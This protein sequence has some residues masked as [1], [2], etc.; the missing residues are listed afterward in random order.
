ML[1]KYLV[2]H[3]WRLVPKGND[4][5]L[6]SP[7]LITI[8][9]V[10]SKGFCAHAYMCSFDTYEFCDSSEID[11]NVIFFISSIA[12]VHDSPNCKLQRSLTKTAVYLIN[13]SFSFVLK[14][15]YV[16]VLIAK[17]ILERLAPI[18]SHSHICESFWKQFSFVCVLNNFKYSS[19][20]FKHT[21]IIS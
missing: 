4:M 11:I 18:K 3:S 14:M 16:I 13:T 17:G 20:K 19:S 8:D 5:I 7:L 6:Y 21:N 9:W 12:E 15:E 1:M 2:G 10:V